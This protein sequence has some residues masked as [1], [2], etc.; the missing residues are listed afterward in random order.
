[1]AAV[2]SLV[3]GADPIDCD[4]VIDTARERLAP[5]KLPR[6]MVTVAVVPRTPSGK[7]D[8]LE[9]TRLF[10]VATAGGEPWAGPTR[11]TPGH[12]PRSS[13]WYGTG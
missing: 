6:Q 11:D 12:S 9:A 10:E 4:E 13:S 1:V 8:Y 7:A 3:P 5:Y 2:V